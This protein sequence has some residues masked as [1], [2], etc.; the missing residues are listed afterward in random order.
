MD[1]GDFSR[2]HE[3]FLNRLAIRNHK[4]GKQGGVQ[5]LKYCIDCGEAIAQGRR[6][7]AIRAGI[8][9][10]RCIE[11]QQQFEQGGR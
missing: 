7:A 4:N 2:E 6:A 11:C 10:R 8:A 5:V 1:E 9:C 3:D